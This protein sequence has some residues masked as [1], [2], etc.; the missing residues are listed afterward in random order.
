MYTSNRIRLRFIERNDLN[1]L[2]SW[3]DDAEVRT[4]LHHAFPM[5]MAIEKRWF[6][7]MIETP[8][9]EHPFLVETKTED[10][11]QAIGTCMLK[12]FDDLVRAAELGIM[13]G[14]KNF[15]HRDFGTETVRMLL[16]HGFENLNL[17][18]IWLSVSAKNQG[19]IRCYEKAGM[20]LE[21]RLREAEYKNGATVDTLLFSIL[22]K[23]WN[24][25]EREEENG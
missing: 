22:K 3:Y 8:L 20:Q 11:C 12:Q 23:E 15:W 10:G 21:A 25:R 4:H 24:K 5:S 16:W 9:R 7:G 2:Q 18:R 14:E 19:A 13:I 1:V 17:H 6:E